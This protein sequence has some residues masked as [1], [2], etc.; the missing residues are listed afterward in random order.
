MSPIRRL[1]RYVRPYR[2]RYGAGIGCL[3]LATVFSLGIPWQVK[4]A[5][6]GL[7]GGGGASRGGGGDG[8]ASTTSAV[9][10]M[11][12]SRPCRRPST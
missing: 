5:V 3:L 10:S 9:T 6:D 2:A 8:G 12:I 4:E 11:S 7:R 1:L